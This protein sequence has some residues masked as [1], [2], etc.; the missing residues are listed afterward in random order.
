MANPTTTALSTPSGIALHDGFSCAIAFERDPDVSLWEKSVKPPGLDGGDPIETT[1]MRNT[2]WRTMRSRSLKT[3]TPVTLTVAYDPNVANNIDN[4]LINQE[5]SITIHY[6]DGSTYDF[7]G[8]LQLFDPSDLTEGEQP[9]ASVTI[10]PTNW[11]PDNDV[12][13]G[14]VLT[15]VS[16]T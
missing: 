16:G 5:G 10:Q 12:E 14:P 13:A 4:N 8:Y 15:E 9:E 1:T 11:D 2:A 6:P 3:L 7:F